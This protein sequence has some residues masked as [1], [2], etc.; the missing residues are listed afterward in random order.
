M[1]LITGCCLKEL[2][3][4]QHTMQH[5]RACRGHCDKNNHLRART[6]FFSLLGWATYRYI[7]HLRRYH[8]FVFSELCFI[9]LGWTSPETQRKK[10]KKKIGNE[11]NQH[12][13]VSENLKYRQTDNT[14]FQLWHKGWFSNDLLGSDTLSLQ[15]VPLGEQVSNILTCQQLCL[16]GI[17]LPSLLHFFLSFFFFCYWYCPCHFRRLIV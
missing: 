14:S 5:K 1:H 9:L 13:S 6:E 4:S 12:R 17:F 2:H 16:C 7:V 8:A 3:S 10:K 11:S 15:D